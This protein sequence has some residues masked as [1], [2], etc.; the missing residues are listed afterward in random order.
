[1]EGKTLVWDIN[2]TEETIK[3]LTDLLGVSN[4]E[5]FMKKYPLS[6][7]FL[8]VLYG[9][10]TMK[11]YLLNSVVD[12]LEDFFIK[13]KDYP[14]LVVGCAI[15]IYKLDKCYTLLFDDLKFDPNM[16]HK[17]F[18]PRFVEAEEMSVLEYAFLQRDKEM[19][20]FLAEMGAK[21]TEQCFQFALDPKRAAVWSV[22]DLE[23]FANVGDNKIDLRKVFEKNEMIATDFSEEEFEPDIYDELQELIENE[24]LEGCKKWIEENGEPDMSELT[25]DVCE[26]EN[27]ELFNFFKRYIGNLNASFHT[28]CY[29]Q[30]E[31]ISRDLAKNHKYRL[32]TC[33]I[34]HFIESGDLD[35]FE[36]LKS[37]FDGCVGEFEYCCIENHQNDLFDGWLEEISS[38]EEYD[39]EELVCFAIENNNWHA[40]EQLFYRIDASMMEFDFV[41]NVVRSARREKFPENYEDL[42][43]SL[44]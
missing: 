21:V 4:I 8:Y 28:F 42:K 33:P 9:T 32:N 17:S 37:D 1:M 34:L 15:Q 27:L 35:A 6:R 3:I 14:Y 2:M 44:N 23:F 40:A 7:K 20:Y 12:H 11:T 38:E 26:T 13:W 5:E 29:F 41:E 10:P 22:D 25:Q 43:R 18:V 39:F 24:D 30:N 16:R 36:K 31:E 19:A